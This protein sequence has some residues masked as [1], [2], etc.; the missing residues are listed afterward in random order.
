MNYEVI[1]MLAEDVCGMPMEVVVDGDFKSTDQTD[2]A[3]KDLASEGMALDNKDFAREALVH[4]GHC[5]PGVAWASRWPPLRRRYPNAEFWGAQ[6]LGTKL[7]SG[8]FAGP[9]ASEDTLAWISTIS[10]LLECIQQWLPISK[11]P[12]L[13]WVEQDSVKH[14][15]RIFPRTGRDRPAPIIASESGVC[16]SHHCC[17]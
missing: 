11:L 17:G 3:M 2:E 5:Q 10:S 15:E 12:T 16:G 1:V 14:V 4:I 9:A 8:L 7:R 13:R 6:W